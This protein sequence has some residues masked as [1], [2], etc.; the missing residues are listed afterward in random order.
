MVQEEGK[1]EE[2][3]AVMEAEAVEVGAEQSTQR[4]SPAQSTAINPLQRIL[5]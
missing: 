3:G 1:A 5:Q 4:S 2:T